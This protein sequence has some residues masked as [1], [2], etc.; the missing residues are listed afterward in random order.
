MPQPLSVQVDEQG[1]II[2][3]LT[4]ANELGLV[5]G[6][7]LQIEPNR[8]RL[9][10][11]PST[12]H[13][14]RLLELPVDWSKQ[15]D[16]TAADDVAK[17]RFGKV[18]EI[19]DDSEQST[20]AFVMYPEATPLLE[21]W[22]AA[23]VANMVIPPKKTNTLFTRSWRAIQEKYLDEIADLFRVPLALSTP[24]RW[25]RWLSLA[26][27]MKGGQSWPTNF[28]GWILTWWS[29][30]AIRRRKN[31]RSGWAKVR[32]FTTASLTRLKPMI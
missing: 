23:V 27:S 32:A 28:A 16:A 2:L 26:F 8:H 7:N 4:L 21:V 22:R 3:P 20:F 25:R 24:R 11:R 14:L 15:L 18:I 30:S 9:L 10:L 17:Q 5:P 13:T 12:G 19:M 31:A 1:R 29:R 6:Q